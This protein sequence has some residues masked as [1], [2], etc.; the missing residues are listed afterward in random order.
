MK[1]KNKIELILHGD[2]ITADK[3]RKSISAFYNF[4]DE[5]AFQVIGKRKP[6]RWIV[7]VEG[8]SIVLANQPE[9]DQLS[10]NVL[11]DYYNFLNTGIEDLNKT[12]E[13]PQYF[14]DQALEYIQELASLPK[15]E[16]GLNKVDIIINRKPHNLTHHIVA[17]VDSILAIYGKSLGSIEG[18]LST[19]SERGELKIVV[20]EKLT[21]KAVRCHISEDMLEKVTVAFRKRVY[22]FGLI[23]YGKDKLPKSINVEEIKILPDKDSIPTA[24]DVYGI[25]RD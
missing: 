20:Y 19:I 2:K 10:P 16:D 5:V 22:V 9:I 24:S 11:D 13:R 7:S 17:N 4:V 23:H 25:L 12:H 6:I 21:D 18:R 3:L 8:G 15:R 1:G 14:S